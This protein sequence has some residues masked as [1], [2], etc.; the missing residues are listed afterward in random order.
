MNAYIRGPSPPLNG[1]MKVPGDKSISHR[2]AILCALATGESVI[3]D[4]GPGRDC[5]STLRCLRSLGVKIGASESNPSC[6]LIEGAGPLSFAEPA[7]VLDCGNSGTTMRL[8]AGVLS[9]FPFFSVLTGDASLRSRPMARIVKPLTAM[10]AVVLGRAAGRLPPLAIKGSRPV[11]GTFDLEVAS[12]QVKSAILLAGLFAEGE[13]AVVEPAPSR[14]HTERMLSAF[15]FKVTTEDRPDGSHLVTVRGLGPPNVPEWSAV[16]GMR[17][18]IPGDMSS[19]AFILA[20]AALV[21]GSEVTLQGVCVNPTRTGFL[22]AM[23]KMGIDIE[24]QT[25]R[26]QSGWEPVG[27]LRIST[28]TACRAELRGA[29]RPVTLSGPA[30]PAVIDEIPLVAVLATQA[31]GTTIVD[32][33][34]E[35]R[36]KETD[37][38]RA[39]AV[40]LAKM[41]A[42]VTE[43]ESGLAIEGPTKLKGAT[44]ESFGDHRIAMAMAVAALAAEGTTVIRDAECAEISYPGFFDALSCLGAPCRLGN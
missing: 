38:L 40:N 21:P 25:R 19:A 41:G 18:R 30:L 33:A 12:A 17:I 13:T 16:G 23:R 37:R 5:A 6:V 1:T 34:G 4:Y 32:D 15:G 10:G 36:V 20:A 35:L 42:S 24:L 14:D 26:D 39:L 29:L 3:D 9:A 8:L 31:A 11:P 2:A 22:E 28:R 7:D 27:N 44:V 43:W